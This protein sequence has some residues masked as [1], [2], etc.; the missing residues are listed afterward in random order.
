MKKGLLIVGGLL[1]VGCLLFVLRFGSALYQ[2]GNPV[3]IVG[4]ILKLEWSDSGFESFEVDHHVSKVDQE[5]VAVK[6]FMEERGWS[7][8]EQMGSGFIFEKSG[9]E[10]VVVE[11]RLFSRHYYLWSVPEGVGE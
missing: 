1:F 2:E 8:V 9:E 4:S 3:P 5:Y 6:S 10:T 11:T 7:F